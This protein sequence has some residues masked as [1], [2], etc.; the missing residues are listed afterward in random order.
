MTQRL[1]ASARTTPTSKIS[2]DKRPF[3]LWPLLIAVVIVAIFLLSSEGSF[4]TDERIAL[5]AQSGLF[6]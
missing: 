2:S 1:S 5:F 4:T 3:L 6:P